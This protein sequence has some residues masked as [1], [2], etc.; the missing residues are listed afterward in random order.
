MVGGIEPGSLFTRPCWAGA[1]SGRHLIFLRHCLGACRI[2][3]RPAC[4]HLSNCLT[5]KMSRHSEMKGGSEMAWK[6][7]GRTCHQKEH[8][9]PLSCLS[10]WCQSETK[11]QTSHLKDLLFP[12][13]FYRI[14]PSS[15]AVGNKRGCESLESHRLPFRFNLTVLTCRGRKHKGKSCC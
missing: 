5:E 12:F 14:L 11:K 3:R 15:I 8:V 1:R 4:V 2:D 7:K 13:I 6:Q 9:A 10:R